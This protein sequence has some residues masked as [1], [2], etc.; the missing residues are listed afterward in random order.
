MT[1][2]DLELMKSIKHQLY[3]FLIL[4]DFS[5]YKQDN[6]GYYF[7]HSKTGLIVYLSKI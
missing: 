1:L 7:L 2:K 6:E 3:E 5:F 4:R